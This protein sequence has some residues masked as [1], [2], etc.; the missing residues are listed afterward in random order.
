LICTVAQADEPCDATAFYNLCTQFN[1]RYENEKYGFRI[2]PNSFTAHKSTPPSQDH[3]VEVSLGDDRLISV[4]ANYDAWFCPSSLECGRQTV[5]DDKPSHIR[6]SD[7]RLAGHKA[8]QFDYMSQGRPT[9]LIDQLRHRKEGD[10]IIYEISL[11]S[12]EAHL[13]QDKDAL[14]KLLASFQEFP[15]P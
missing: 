8:V 1:G 7:M 15:T 4:F 2:I 13:T 9:V 6:I 12:D 3:G 10:A 11:T 5:K 14:S